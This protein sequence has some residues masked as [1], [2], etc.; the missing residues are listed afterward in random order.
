MVKE[1]T[2]YDE[3]GEERKLLQEQGL[4]PD[5]CTTLAYQMLK[6][7]MLNDNCSDLKSLYR[8]IAKHA[9]SYTKSPEE[10]EEKFYDLFWKGWLA[11]STPVLDNM[12]K[13]VGCAVSCSGGTISD[14]IYDF[15]FG[16][17]EA[18]VLT[19]NGFGTS[20]YLGNIRPRG[21]SINGI[22]GKASGILPVFKDFVQ[23]SRDVSQTGRRGAW[24]GYLEIDHPDFYEILNYIQ[25]FPDDANVGWNITDK[26]IERLDN[27]D[28]DAIERYQKALK[29]KMIT[30][31]GYFHFIDKVNRQNPPMY[32]DRNATVKASN[33]CVAP[34]TLILTDCG[35]YPIC[36]LEDQY[37]NIW[38]G[39]EFSNVQVKK[40]GTNQELV[41]VIT[42]DGIELYC[43]PYHKFYI[44]KPFSKYSSS[45]V[46]VSASELNPGD[47][48]IKFDLPVIEGD[49][50]LD[51][52]YQN[53]F[54]S[55]DGCQF[56]HGSRLL[57]RIY[58]YNEKRKLVNEF[59]SI[60]TTWYVQETQN[61]EYGECP[62]LK[63]KF[64]IPTS[65]YTIESRVSWLEGL[66]DADGT[67]ARLGD[68]QTL[69]LVSN[70]KDFIT[71]VQ[72]MLQELGVSS[73]VKLMR[74]SGEYLLPKNDGSGE[75]GFYNCKKLYRILISGCGITKLKFLG[76]SPKRLILNDSIPNRNAERFFTIKEVLYTDRKDDTYCVHEP[77]RNMA[78]FNGILTGNCVEISLFSDEEHT[79]SC[80]LSS[81]NLS[82]Y[83]EWKNTD[84]VFNATVFLD[85]VN[86]DL[87][88][89]GKRTKGMEKI[90][91]FAEKTRALGLGVLGFHTYLQ[92]H[93]IP[94][95]STEA[96]I[97]NLE[98][99]K[100]IQEETIRASKWMAETLGEPEWCKGY[101]VRNTHLT[102]VPPTLTSSL[103]AG[104]VSQGVEP[105]YKNAYVQNTAA[106][107]MN[108]VNPS[109]LKIMKER[110]VFNDE[111]I[112]DIISNEGSVQHVSWL[113]ENEKEV[114]KTAF[115]INQKQIIR[116]ASSRQ[117][118]ID[119]S[120]SI[121]LFFSANEDEEYISEVHKEAF[122]DPYLKSLYYIR[123]SNGVNVN[124]ESCLS[125]HG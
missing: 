92:D 79:F 44:N 32:K 4:L 27:G 48:L 89:I 52:A 84:A 35:Y 87:I 109:L 110:H 33:L 120:Q 23:L 122:K 103:I 82:K 62:Y 112:K 96:Y 75:N 43:T 20:A 63:D 99:F 24:A 58:L 93:M 100:H 59:K 116:L 28:I 83:D 91:R 57:K 70:N 5:W 68:S 123:S 31:K 55:G 61:R 7:K 74:E 80:V 121:N 9:S 3:L 16:Q 76:F 97:L 78:M 40:T 119:Q 117:K 49:K 17:V 54:F 124:K 67:V 113:S 12:G 25:K 34:E 22:K 29:L 102:C 21:S 26:F 18:A 115:E 71:S 108:R 95:E 65:E 37:V 30:G 15:Y 6:D 81:M 14:N 64:F 77:K 8:R 53:G 107:K 69:Q 60:C 106:G 105:I 88:E 104:S 56:V 125:C 90:V 51:Y 38:N 47:K 86:Q 98:M 41:K 45:V 111:T 42:N 85:C 39:E 118:F 19:K 72:L 2:I 36:E 101:G 10:W 13:G 73:K 46:K 1:K 114:F 50:T 66:F 11:G 94:F